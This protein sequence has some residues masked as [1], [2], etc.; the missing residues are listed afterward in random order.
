MRPIKR[1]SLKTIR[2]LFISKF[3]I[4]FSYIYGIKK[5]YRKLILFTIDFLLILLSIN[6]VTYFLYPVNNAIVNI[7]SINYKYDEI[8]SNNWLILILI[9]VIF[10]VFNLTGQY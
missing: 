6:I 8:L 10:V 9:L 1:I 4:I 7:T 5:G 3:L 2:E